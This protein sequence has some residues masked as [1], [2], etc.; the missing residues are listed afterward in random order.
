MRD[1]LTG[2]HNRLYLEESLRRLQK[3]VLRDIRKG[4][5]TYLI[6]VFMDIDKFKN[7]NDS[8]GHAFG[9]SAICTC[10]E[11]M[12]QEIR[13]DTENYLCRYGGDE[14]CAALKISNSDSEIEALNEVSIICQRI[15]ENL[16]KTPFYCK[17]M[18]ILLSITMGIHVFNPNE[19]I[20]EAL[21]RA[22]AEMYAKKH[23]PKLNEI[24]A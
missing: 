15:H 6:L 14:F 5:Q 12:R 21:S 10:A 17:S 20:M 22:D 1:P 19:D 11:I 8:Y 18:R 16:S 9:D 2:L 4:Q 23:K 7:I 13:E 24:Q 3:Q